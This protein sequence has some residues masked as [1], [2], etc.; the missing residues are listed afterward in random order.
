MMGVRFGA[1]TWRRSEYLYAMYDAICRAG[2][3][4]ADRAK[5][6]MAI[7]QMAARKSS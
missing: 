1:P 5:V 2:M 6:P 3:A 7:R 4:M